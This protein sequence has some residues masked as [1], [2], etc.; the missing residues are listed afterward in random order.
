MI[1]EAGVKFLNAFLGQLPRRGTRTISIYSNV[2]Q[3]VRTKK[4]PI[5]FYVALREKAC[6]RP[7]FLRLMKRDLK[8]V[9]IIRI[10]DYD[11]CKDYIRVQGEKDFEL[12]K[13]TRV[14]VPIA[15]PP[16]PALQRLLDERGSGPEVAEIAAAIDSRIVKMARGIRSVQL[17]NYGMAYR[18]RHNFAALYPKKNFVRVS[19]R[20]SSKWRPSRI[21]RKSQVRAIIS[22][23][24]RAVRRSTA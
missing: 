8:S 15:T 9:G 7:D 17:G 11:Q 22:R 1:Y 10:N 21:K 20:E 14:E 6:A 19:V 13:A 24:R 12:C 23:I 4:V 3:F 16:R 5:L 18:I 2:A